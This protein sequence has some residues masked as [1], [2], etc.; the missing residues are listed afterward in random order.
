MNNQEKLQQVFQ[1]VLQKLEEINAKKKMEEQKKSGFFSENDIKD[2][3]EEIDGIV[4]L[5]P[6]VKKIVENIYVF[7]PYLKELTHSFALFRVNL[8]SRVFNTYLANGFSREEAMTLTLRENI[9][10]QKMIGEIKFNKG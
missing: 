1:E 8:I 10:Y 3:L 4:K 2:V 7:T 9:D 6:I 5:E